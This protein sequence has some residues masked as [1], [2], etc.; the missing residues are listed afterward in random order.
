MP[1]GR[2]VVKA[3]L[4]TGDKY[5]NTI[6]LVEW[7]KKVPAVQSLFKQHNIRDNSIAG[8]VSLLKHIAKE[9]FANEEYRHARLSLL[10]QASGHLP[11]DFTLSKYD[12]VTFNCGN[13]EW[14]ILTDEEATKRASDYIKDLLWA[15][16]PDFLE[17]KT[18]LPKEM[19]QAIIDNG[20]CEDNN[21][22][23]E[24]LITATCGLDV[25]TKEAI[26]ADGRGHFISN[27]D[28][29][30]IEVEGYFCYRLN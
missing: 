17:R 12:S 5:L 28:G 26:R 23:M 10:A 13:E 14:I 4:E 7:D 15:F 21:Q 27:Y 16:N 18:D 6:P 3:A 20:K 2:E 22:V 19:F 8:A 1:V 25:F 9:Y 30:E 29:K 11:E 24:K